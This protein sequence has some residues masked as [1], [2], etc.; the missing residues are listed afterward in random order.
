MLFI[1]VY[2]FVQMS[3]IPWKIYKYNLF[4]LSIPILNFVHW[5]QI[6]RIELLHVLMFVNMQIQFCVIYI[7]INMIIKEC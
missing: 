3:I 2:K 6:M 7:F 5:V 4:L 1:I